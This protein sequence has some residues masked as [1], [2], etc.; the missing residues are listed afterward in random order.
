MDVKDFLVKYLPQKEGNVLDEKE[1]IIGKHPG[2]LLFTI[3]ERHGFT[4]TKKTPNDEPLFVVS[5]N[6]EKNTITVAK[7][8][9]NKNSVFSPCG[10]QAPSRP[11]VS[12]HFGARKSERSAQ[13][14]KCPETSGL[15]VRSSLK[16]TA[17]LFSSQRIVEISDTNWISE[18]PKIAK[19]FSA[20]IRYRAPLFSCVISKISDTGATV[21]FD[22][23]QENITPGQSLVLYDGDVCL[24]GGIIES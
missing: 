2:A 20:R 22:E 24:G 23:P 13:A 19:R 21:T 3:G 14:T 11:E 17:F 1:N 12:G 6:M 18:A 4:I 8:D 10:T 15:R 9:E 5:K 7:R 16:N